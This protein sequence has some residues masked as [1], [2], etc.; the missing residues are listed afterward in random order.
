MVQR[1]E[2][3]EG[4]KLLMK[5]GAWGSVVNSSFGVWGS[6]IEADEILSI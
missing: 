5:I 2:I 4:K 3:S 1:E 6:G